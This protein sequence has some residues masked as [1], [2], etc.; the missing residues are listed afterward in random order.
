MKTSRDSGRSRNKSEL[1]FKLKVSWVFPIFPWFFWFGPQLSS[2]G[3]WTRICLQSWRPPR[4]LSGKE[5]HSFW[6]LGSSQL[7]NPFYVSAWLRYVFFTKVRNSHYMPFDC[8]KRSGNTPCRFVGNQWMISYPKPKTEHATPTQKACKQLGTCGKKC[9]R[10]TRSPSRA[11]GS[12]PMSA[13]NRFL[14]GEGKPWLVHMWWSLLVIVD[15]RYK[16]WWCQFGDKDS[17]RGQMIK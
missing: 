7:T 2:P 14:L 10:A 3:L 12:R 6:R 1:E 9:S 11:S 17:G 5:S 4:S 13:R 16:L 8:L 15:G